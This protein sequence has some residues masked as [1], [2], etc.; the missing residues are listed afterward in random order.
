[1]D[2]S[3]LILYKMDH[4][5]LVTVNTFFFNLKYVNVSLKLYVIG[6][7][8]QKVTQ[9]MIKIINKYRYSNTTS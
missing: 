1:M 7:W 8:A 5:T 6:G 3:I 9:F 2:P 4:I